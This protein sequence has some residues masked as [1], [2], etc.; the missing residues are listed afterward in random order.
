MEG[1]WNRGNDVVIGDAAHAPAPQ[2]ASGAAL[3]IE[4]GL[5]LAEELGLRR[6]VGAGLEA[7]VRRRG[8]RCRTLVETSVAIAGLEHV[9]RRREAYPLTDAGHR[10]MA[11]PA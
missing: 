8:Q 1:A 4:D 7:F 6:S 11:E 5:V 2:M 9:R 3:A 10:L